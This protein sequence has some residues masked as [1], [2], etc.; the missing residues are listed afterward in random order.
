[1]KLQRNSGP[2]YRNLFER[3]SHGRAIYLSE[4]LLNSE[5]NVHAA[6]VLRVWWILCRG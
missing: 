2:E 5:A 4:G 1:M 3:T 6:D